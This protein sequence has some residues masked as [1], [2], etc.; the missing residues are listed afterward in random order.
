M[1]MDASDPVKIVFLI[2]FIIVVIWIIE[3]GEQS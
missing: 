1:I 3:I 2:L